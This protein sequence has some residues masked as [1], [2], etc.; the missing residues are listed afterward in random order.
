MGLP[1]LA[2]DRGEPRLD[3]DLDAI[4]RHR[5][6]DPIAFDELVKRHEALIHGLVLRYVKNAEDARDLTQQAFVR[7]FERI[8]TFRG[9]SSFR[10]WLYRIAINLALSFLR[11][12]PP[13]ATVPLEDVTAFTT[14]L[15]TSRLMAAEVWR[16]VSVRLDQLS[17][18]QRLVVE[19]RL[20]HDLS[21][22]E[23]AAIADSSEESVRTTYHQAIR[24]LR[25]L[26]CG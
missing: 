21:F 14:S 11:G 16:K 24:R 18:L 26:L 6:G 25:D 23:V 12:A 8:D 13:A 9:V 2:S 4:V 10:T 1:V 5:A 7:A 15:G 3:A 17:P 20:F 22:K 19:L